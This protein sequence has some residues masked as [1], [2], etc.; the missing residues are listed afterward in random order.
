MLIGYII[1]P[2]QHPQ[3]EISEF[4]VMEI[5]RDVTRRNMDEPISDRGNFFRGLDFKTLWI[6][7]ITDCGG[8]LTGSGELFPGLDFNSIGIS[9]ITVHGGTWI[10]PGELFSWA[11][12]QNKRDFLHNGAWGNLDRAGGTFFR[13]WISKRL[14]FAS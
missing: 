12:F 4:V 9:L 1:I 14:G 13:G 2:V 8:T 7:F 10:G 11:G 5:S 6:S 3:T